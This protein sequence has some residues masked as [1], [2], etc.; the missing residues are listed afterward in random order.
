MLQLCA[1]FINKGGITLEAYHGCRSVVV[2]QKLHYCTTRRHIWEYRY[3]ASLLVRRPCRVLPL[4][5][6][7]IQVWQ[8]AVGQEN[9]VSL[10]LLKYP[11]LRAIIARLGRWGVLCT[12]PHGYSSNRNWQLSGPRPPMWRVSP[13]GH[14]RRARRP[15]IAAAWQPCAPRRTGAIAPCAAAIAAGWGPRRRPKPFQLVWPWPWRP[16]CG[17][18]RSWTLATTGLVG[19]QRQRRSY[20]GGSLRASGMHRPTPLARPAVSWAPWLPAA[21]GPKGSRPP[22][23]RSSSEL[24]W[25][26]V[27]AFV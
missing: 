1:I 4:Q 20:G 6:V 24:H 7:G 15:S 16:R 21:T 27:A 25:V 11:P 23:P 22:F 8:E 13:G 5:S 2:I 14:P 18:R 9:G 10:S 19:G 3:C 17:P 12:L 26:R